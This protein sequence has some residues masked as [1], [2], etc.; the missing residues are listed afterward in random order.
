MITNPCWHADLR[1]PTGA[2]RFLFE[3]VTLSVNGK[4]PKTAIR[5][6]MIAMNE[7]WS[8]RTEGKR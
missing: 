3:V 2:R 8:V 6:I 5:A 1:D 4:Q 7:S